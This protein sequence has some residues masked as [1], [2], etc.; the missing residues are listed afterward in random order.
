[1]TKNMAACLGAAAL[2]AF[3]SALA[4]DVPASDLAALEGVD[5]AWMK[6]FNSGNAEALAGLY[7]EKAVLLPPG[8][9]AV[10]GR[11]AIRKFFDKEVAEAAKAGVS[12]SLASR[13]A[14]GVSANMG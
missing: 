13:P 8:A 2:I 1:M 10:S 11:S 6:A 9:A 14:G 3:G 12:F 4:A 5:Q 7:D